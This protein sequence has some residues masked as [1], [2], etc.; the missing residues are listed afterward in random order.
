M[1]VV[2]NFSIRNGTITF[3]AAIWAS[4]K[5]VADGNTKVTWPLHTV[6]EVRLR[7]GGSTS[8]AVYIRPEEEE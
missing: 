2:Q 3:D 6:R 7:W 5:N 4:P 1:I 8:T